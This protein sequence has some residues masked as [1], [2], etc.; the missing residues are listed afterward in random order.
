MSPAEPIGVVLVALFDLGANTGGPRRAR[1]LARLL[2]HAGARPHLVGYRAPNRAGHE[3]SAP[4]LAD[5][6]AT[7]LIARDATAGAHR[8]RYFLGLPWSGAERE[9]LLRAIGAA[10]G[11]T[12]AR[13]L[14]LY[15]QDAI[16]ARAIA[17]LCREQRIA[18]VQHYA[19]AHVSA[20][21]RLG[22]LT[23]RWW[24]ERRHLR[25]SPRFAAGRIVISRWLRDAVDTRAAGETI[26]LPSFVD[27]AEWDASLAATPPPPRAAEPHLLYAGDGARRDSVPLIA[28]AVEL[29]RRRGFPCRVSFVGPGGTADG[30]FFPRA[31]APELAAHYR[32]ADALI[33]LRTDDQSSR[34]CLPTRLGEFLLT[35]RPVIVSDLPDYNLYLRD[36][37]NGYVV[38]SPSVASVADAIQ[39]ALERTPENAA[40]GQRGRET[41]LAHF[42]WRA[43]RTAAAAWLRRVVNGG[44]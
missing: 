43:H 38:R 19:E 37:D 35:A 18:F 32:S 2:A 4:L 31:S 5:G 44:N 41:A 30:V 24:S 15:N 34:A 23:G 22:V 6:V 3:I 16:A 11:A 33:L 10:L 8:V 9:E 26:L 39:A 7:T 20:D 12:R 1:Q 28:E 36:R 14:V 29:V 13:A 21:F 40:I 17:R 25:S 42:D 27:V